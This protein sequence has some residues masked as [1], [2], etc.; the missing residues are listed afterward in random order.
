MSLQLEF[1][2]LLPIKKVKSAE[3]TS[4]SLKTGSATIPLAAGLP[5]MERRGASLQRALDLHLHLSMGTSHS[6]QLP[7]ALCP[8]KYSQ[9]KSL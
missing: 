1:S 8:T 9:Q 3:M 6:P 4:A 5:L 7:A 2:A